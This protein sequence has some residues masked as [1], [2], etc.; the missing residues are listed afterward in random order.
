MC[1]REREIDLVLDESSFE[2]GTNGHQFSL[3]VLGAVCTVC[4][5]CAG[6]DPWRGAGALPLLRAYSAAFISP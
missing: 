4:L 2:L 6:G 3:T 5:P 1:D